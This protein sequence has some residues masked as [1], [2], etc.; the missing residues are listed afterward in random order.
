MIFKNVQF[1]DFLVNI[2]KGSKI[3][4]IILGFFSSELPVF[5]SNV[6]VVVVLETFPY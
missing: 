3:G 5:F 4:D 1:K 2:F 6:F